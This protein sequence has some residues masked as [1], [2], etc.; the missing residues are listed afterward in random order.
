MTTKSLEFDF[1]IRDYLR[2]SLKEPVVTALF[3]DHQYH[4][5]TSVRVKSLSCNNRTEHYIMMDLIT[6]T[7][8]GDKMKAKEFFDLTRS[9]LAFCK[10]NSDSVSPKLA[11]QLVFSVWKF[12]YV[13]AL[14]SLYCDADMTRITSRLHRPIKRIHMIV[15]NNVNTVV[16]E[17]R[18]IAN[19]VHLIMETKRYESKIERYVKGIK[20]KQKQLTEV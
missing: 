10:V 6:L 7:A 4:N 2:A 13:K 5:I 15:V 11:H 18:K 20:D 9:F 12:C 1:K 8:N 3:Y 17:M 16:P 19:N 14:F